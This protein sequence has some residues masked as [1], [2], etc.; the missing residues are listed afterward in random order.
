MAI[1]TP[2]WAR[3]A[4]A[5]VLGAVL[6]T[7]ASLQLLRHLQDVDFYEARNRALFGF[8]RAMH[9]PSL[10]VTRTIVE[11]R[12][13]TLGRLEEFGGYER[14]KALEDHAAYDLELASLEREIL[15]A[16]MRRR[17]T[18]ALDKAREV[19]V[20]TSKDVREAL[21]QVRTSVLPALAYR[22]ETVTLD[23]VEISKS[24]WASIEHRVTTGSA[25]WPTGIRAID[26]RLNGGAR[27]RK[28][29]IIGARPSVGKS[30]LACQFLA[31]W[32]KR[33]Y[34][35]LMFSLEMEPEDVGQ[36]LVQQAGR[37]DVERMI[38]GAEDRLDASL[39][40]DA[41]HR[42]ISG[43]EETATWTHH[44]AP[45]GATSL[46]DILSITRQHVATYGPCPVII[47][48]LQLIETEERQRNRSREEEVSI[49]SRTLRQELAREVG[50]SVWVLCQLNRN[51]ESRANQRPKLADLRESGSLEQNADVVM[52]L[53]RPPRV[54]AD[55]L[56]CSERELR[57]HPS[58]TCRNPREA[59]ICIPKQRRGWTGDIKAEWYGEFQLFEFADKQSAEDERW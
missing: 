27:A 48:Y 42:T 40:G 28:Q 1:D 4:E 6:S 44:L 38:L 56:G 12:A 31:A 46:T 32:G 50:C 58:A 49:I 53:H 9:E 39:E 3:V 36:V 11:A 15:E 52:L 10:P 41:Y 7:S 14:L 43:C 25:E 30:A 5:R 35:P 18:E 33:G 24:T 21:E 26:A 57:N 37:V 20:D 8:I 29:Y 13:A 47:D 16:S 19:A 22:G 17:A 45:A 55:A 59:M 34:H 23:S 51:L 2:T 54:E